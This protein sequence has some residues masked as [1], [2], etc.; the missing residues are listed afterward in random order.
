MLK[1]IITVSVLG[2]SALGMMTA[3]AATNG[4]Y[5]LGQAGYANTHMKDK[6]VTPL[7]S[8]GSGFSIPNTGF[9]GRLAIGYQFNPNIAVELG[10]LQLQKQKGTFKLAPTSWYVPGTET[11]QQNAIDLVAKGILPISDK[12]NVYGKVGVAYLTS[13][14]TSHFEG[15]GKRNTNAA[16]NIAKHKLAPEVGLG[17]TYNVTNNIFVDTSWTHIQPLGKNRPNNID[18]ASVGIGYSFG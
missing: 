13:M 14:I 5:V 2:A 8:K 18:V 6:I 1:K 10:Y 15:Q 12:F 7:S 16:F 17:V 11:L 3:N 4:I 9:A